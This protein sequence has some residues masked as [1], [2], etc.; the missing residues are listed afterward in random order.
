MAISYRDSQG[1]EIHTEGGTS[2]SI[3]FV[4]TDGK[5]TEDATNLSYNDTTNVLTAIMN[6]KQNTNPTGFCNV[7]TH[8]PVTGTDTAF[9]THVAFVT[10]VF[11][12]VQKTVTTVGYLVG[13]VGGT[14]LCH[15]VIWGDGGTVVGN[16]AT[17][18]T[19]VG[20]AATY[21]ALTLAST[22]TLSA[23][24]TYYIGIQANGATAKLR[25]VP[26][27]TAPWLNCG[28]VSITDGSVSDITVPSSFSAAGEAP[29]VYIR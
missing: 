17:V 10:S 6:V 19:T 12:P 8:S 18:G 3:A 11:V 28:D 25:T 1:R 7:Q 29:Y 20:T 16:S 24:A 26:A 14:D 5:L 22:V 4:N 23:P 9:A 21:Q 27:N 2:G 13:S 15:A